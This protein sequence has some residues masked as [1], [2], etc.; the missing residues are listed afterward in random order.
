ML[1]SEAKSKLVLFPLTL[2]LLSILP[3]IVY[4][5]AID[6]SLWPNYSWLDI[7]SNFL[8]QK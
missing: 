2:L 3:S 6:S 4:S 7:Q 1:Y 8:L 5:K